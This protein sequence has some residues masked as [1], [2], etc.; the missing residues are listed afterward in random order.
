MEATCASPKKCNKCAIT[1]GQPLPHSW[2]DATCTKNQY[3]SECGTSG[4]IKALGHEPKDHNCTSDSS[5]KR[6]NEMIPATG[7]DLTEAT[8]TKAATCKTCN[9]IIGKAL[10]HTTNNG[11]CERCDEKITLDPKL[12]CLLC[13][14]KLP[15]CNNVMILENVANA[16]QMVN[17]NVNL[18]MDLLIATHVKV[19]KFVNIVKIQMTLNTN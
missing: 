14:E 16:I 7:H 9:D 13:E 18:A 10:G 4:T 11:T 3:C 17:M 1:E 12:Y 19:V 6:C 2:V 15:D 5:C 8:C